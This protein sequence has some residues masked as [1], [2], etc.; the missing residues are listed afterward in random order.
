ML[1]QDAI[2]CSKKCYTN[3]T[4]ATN[5]KKNINWYND[6]KNGPLDPNTSNKILLDRLLVPGNYANLWKGKRNGGKTKR[7]IGELIANEIINAGVTSVRNGKQVE[8]KI[9]HFEKNI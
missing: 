8:N 1:P 3:L 9:A 6:G 5:A 2:V 4:S 7:A